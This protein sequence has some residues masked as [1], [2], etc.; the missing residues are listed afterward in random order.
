[1]KRVLV[2]GAGI[3]GLVTAVREHLAKNQVFKYLLSP[4]GFAAPRLGIIL[5]YNASL[6]TMCVARP[7]PHPL[8][9]R[10]YRRICIIRYHEITPR[11]SRQFGDDM[12]AVTI[13]A[14]V[15]EESK[16]EYQIKLL[17]GKW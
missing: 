3:H 9:Q 1:M 2:V 8:L 15:V 17:V 16:I 4:Q 7:S 11:Y 5:A 12:L 14:N 10:M 6:F 13:V